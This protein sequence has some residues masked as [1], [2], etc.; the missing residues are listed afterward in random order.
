MAL[1]P[2]LGDVNYL[3][4]G[5]M[6]R[7]HAPAHGGYR[8]GGF[9]L[10]P[11]PLQAAAMDRANRAAAAVRPDTPGSPSRDAALIPAA[12][13][14][15][16]FTSA[17]GLN[18][19]VQTMNPQTAMRGQRIFA[20]VLRSG[21]SAAAT[22]PLIQFLQIGMK[23]IITTADGVPIEALNQTTFDMNVL[24]PPT[25]PGVVYSLTMRLPVALGAGDTIT[26]IC[27]IHG[28]AVL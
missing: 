1:S 7:V 4:A 23:P 5:P 10:Q 12:W 18:S 8:G 17:T 15:F 26:V 28:S 22:A 14:V 2:Y 21:A 3:G 19:I 16:A 6:V 25:E 9:A 13:P 20:T 11:T 27:G 24:L